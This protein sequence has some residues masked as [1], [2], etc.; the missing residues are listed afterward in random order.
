VAAETPYQAADAVRAI[1]VDYEVLPFVVDEL[2]ALKSGAPEVREG[3]NKRATDKYERGDINKGFAEAD[4]VLEDSYKAECQFHSCP[5]PQGCVANWDGD[6]LTVWTGTQGVYFPIQAEISAGLGLPLSKCRVVCKYAGGGFG[7]K[8][9]TYVAHMAAPLLAKKTGRP[10]KIAYEAEE[11]LYEGG[12]APPHNVKVK[13][14]VKKDG[15][16]T[17]YHYATI[18]TGGH[19]SSGGIFWYDRPYRD[20]YLCPNVLTEATDVYIHGS[21]SWPMRAPCHPQATWAMEQM[22][23]QLAE[24]LGMDPVEFRLKN[25]PTFAQDIEGNPPYT[26]T[27]LKECIADGAKE[28]GWKEARKNA[29][30][31]RESPI[32]RGVGMSSGSFEMGF[33]WPPST[34]IVKLGRDGSVKLEMGISDMGTGGKSALAMVVAEELGIKPEFIHLEYGDTATTAVEQVSAG[35]RTIPTATP[36]VRDACIQIKQQ[37][38]EMAAKD[39]E[40]DPAT[41]AVQGGQVVSTKDPDK[42]VKFADI[43]GLKGQ[44][45]IVGVAHAGA[46]PPGKRV[47]PFCAHFCEVEVNMKTMEVKVVRYLAAHESGRVI[48]RAGYEGQ[49][50]GGVV[51][52]IGHALTEWRIFDKEHMGK[53]LTRNLHDYK[54]PTIMDVPVEIPVLTVDLG[55]TFSNTGAKGVGEPPKVPPAAAVANA[56]FHATGIR[57]TRSAI[58]PLQLKA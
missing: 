4:V 23:D 54:M 20:L 24:K 48:F 12:N 1:K 47:K 41:L 46:N 39:L 38:L 22:M 16:L 8:T 19:I 31:T 55:D 51:Q 43:S 35:S 33:I 29:E 9:H 32:R 50:V 34:A 28:F 42:K 58:N 49:V 21:A 40:V 18:N 26:T 3:G 57:F 17:A 14:G 36:P 25:I 45:V 27:G 7:G 44:Q 13:A 2:E 6:Y 52:G 56:V 15:T 37:L 10:V 5:E 53:T 30:A 11:N